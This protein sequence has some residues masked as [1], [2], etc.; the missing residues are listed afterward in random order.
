MTRSMLVA[1]A[2]LLT[3][4]AAS[5]FMAPDTIEITEGTW[6]KGKE[7][8]WCKNRIVVGTGSFQEC[9]SIIANEQKCGDVTYSNP[10]N[11]K[12]FCVPAGGKCDESP[13]GWTDLYTFTPPPPADT[14]QISEGTWSRKK[15]K[16]W[17]KNRIVVGTG[18]FEECLSKIAN[19]D[20]CEG[21]TYSNPKNDKCFC[22]PKGKT[23]DEGPAGWT[24]IYTFA[25]TPPGPYRSCDEQERFDVT[26]CK[27]FMC[28]KCTLDWCMQSCQEVQLDFPT[29]R[30]ESWPKARKTYSGGEFA[31][32]G[33]Y[34]DAGD[35][36]K[37]A[38][39]FLST[40]ITDQD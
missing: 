38:A 11:D 2:L 8:T 16:T 9:L 24:D 15:T 5:D 18:T 6:T 37:A 26:M 29:C 36:A 17:C 30:C 19:D 25:A 33:K 28:T 20:K 35:Y 21:V 7:K 14:I 4:V 34:G 32:K 31:S 39:A 3:G 1:F 12:C 22:V 27:S 13:A 40:E 10:K 23:C